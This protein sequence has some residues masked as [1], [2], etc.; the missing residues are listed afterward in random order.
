MATDAQIPPQ[1]TQ[2]SRS[3]LLA[4][5]WHTAI[6]IAML[7]I[8]SLNGTRGQHTLS[9]GHKLALY[10]WTM[11]WEWIL[12]G[13]VWLGIRKR[14]RLRDLIGGRW[15]TME[16]FFLDVVFA[17]AFWGC[18][19]FVLGIGAK[20]M[21]LDH[22]GK[23]ESMRRQIGISESDDE[24]GAR[25]VVLRERDRRL[26]RRDHFSRISA[27]AVRRDDELDAQW[28]AALGDRVW[29][30]ARL[31][32]RRAHDFNRNFRINVWVTRL[33]AKKPSRRNDG[34]RVARRAEWRTFASV[35]IAS[36]Y[37]ASTHV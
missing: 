4:P 34:A 11:A 24:P 13:T 33:V 15:A 22:P 31:R 26:L 9:G 10:F 17:G 14:I 3:R 32:R 12:T 29:G 30:V 1:N 27:A 8:V 23:F 25:R 19:M 20:L 35:E 21:H 36:V 2:A 28:S 18:A 7:L 5:W 16:D 6:L 37:A